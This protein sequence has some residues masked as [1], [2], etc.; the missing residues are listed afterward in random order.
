MKWFEFYIGTLHIEIDINI[1]T[2]L[3]RVFVNGVLVSELQSFDEATTHDI[4]T[5]IEGGRVHL[6]IVTEYGGGVYA[7]T[8]K[9]EGSVIA[10][11]R[12]PRLRIDEEND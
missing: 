11:I 6:E 12:I 1:V 4:D 10:N 9:R 3:E 5:E 8:V 7:C 2:G